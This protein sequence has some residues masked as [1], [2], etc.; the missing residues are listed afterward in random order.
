MKGFFA[1]GKRKWKI[2]TCLYTVGF[3]LLL[4][5]T[6]ILL[7]KFLP[8][9]LFGQANVAFKISHNIWCLYVIFVLQHFIFYQYQDL[10]FF[11]KTNKT[12]NKIF[13][14]FVKKMNV[15]QKQKRKLFF[16]ILVMTCFCQINVLLSVLSLMWV[17]TTA[18]VKKK[19]SILNSFLNTVTNVF[20]ELC[21]HLH[22]E[23]FIC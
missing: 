22:F 18:R 9:F 11:Y 5:F 15:K 17:F 20:S 6:F 7:F 19:E 14:I 3:A 13:I 12:W 10:I 8:L 16:I 23:E 1:L 2:C 4:K 21:H